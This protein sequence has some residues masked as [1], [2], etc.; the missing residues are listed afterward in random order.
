MTVIQRL[1]EAAQNERVFRGATCNCDWCLHK[2]APLDQAVAAVEQEL[3]AKDAEIA[4]LRVRAE[5]AE[6]HLNQLLPSGLGP[7][8]AYQ[9]A[10]LQQAVKCAEDAARAWR[11]SDEWNPAE[12]A[13]EQIGKMLLDVDRQRLECSGITSFDP[14]EV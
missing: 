2:H 4:E 12:F 9:A 3:A 5:T 6:R 8:Y 7:I 11:E 1:R 14:D 10:I 13:A